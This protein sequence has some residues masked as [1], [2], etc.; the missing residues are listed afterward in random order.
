LTRIARTAALLAVLLVVL[1][2]A[3]IALADEPFRLESQITDRVGALEG[4]RAEVQAAIDRLQQEDRIQLWV[5]YVDSFDGQ[6][7]QE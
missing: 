3:P 6:G 4:R 2:T 1:V 7:A 5:V